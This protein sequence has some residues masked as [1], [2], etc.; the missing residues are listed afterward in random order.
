VLEELK[1]YLKKS[2]YLKSKCEELLNN[3]T[4][5]SKEKQSIRVP[6]MLQVKPK[7]IKELEPRFSDNIGPETSTE[8]GQKNEL[9]KLKRQLKQEQKGA[10]RELRKDT[11]VIQEE[12]RKAKEIRDK[13]LDKKHKEVIGFL[14]NQQRDSNLMRRLSK[15]KF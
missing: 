12:K 7:Q 4:S 14:Q 11:F 9:S 5:E 3:L 1:I 13:E 8:K 2:K 15:K 10:R 6:L